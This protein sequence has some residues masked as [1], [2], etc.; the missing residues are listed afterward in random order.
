MKLLAHTQVRFRDEAT[1]HFYQHKIS[2]HR[3]LWIQKFWKVACAWFE[4]RLHR[5]FFEV[6]RMKLLVWVS[7]LFCFCQERSQRAIPPRLGRQCREKQEC[8]LFRTKQ[9]TR[10]C[11]RLFRQCSHVFYLL[12]SCPVPPVLQDKLR[13]QSLLVCLWQGSITLL[14]QCEKQ[15]VSDSQKVLET[16]STRLLQSQT[17]QC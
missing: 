16:H 11:F 3:T 10:R 1:K 8:F 12:S 17:F 5:E 4:E 14:P 15:E 7:F 6:R 2:C 9:K 13:V